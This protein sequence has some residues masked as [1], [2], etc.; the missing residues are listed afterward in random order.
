VFAPDTRTGALQ[1]VTSV[2]LD[3]RGQKY[4][5][6]SCV[7][8]HGGTPASPGQLAQTAP[9]YSSTAPSG[10]YGDVNAGFLPWDLTSF[11]YSDTDPGFSQK[12]EDA[13]LKA[14]YTE[15]N[16]VGQ[17]KLLNVGAYLTTADPNRYALERELLEGWY[18]GPGLP[19]AYVGNFVPA[20]WQ[21]T[22]NGNP[23]T[24]AMLYTDVFAHS[25]RACHIMQA[26]AAGLNLS[27]GGASG[28]GSA[29]CTQATSTTHLGL[30][31]DQFPI[32]C[33]WQFANQ[34]VLAQ[35]VSQARMPFARR[36]ADRLWV[37]PAGDPAGS[38]TSA[39]GQELLTDLTSLYASSSNPPKVVAPGTPDVS[40][41]PFPKSM[42]GGQQADVLSWLTLGVT[43]GY[44]TDGEF[45]TQPT[46]QVCVDTGSGS[47]AGSTQQISVVG[48]GAIPAGFQ[49]PYSGNFLAELDSAGSKL[50]TQSL[51]VPTV[52]PHINAGALPAQ[53]A[54]QGSL[55]LVGDNVV[56]AGNGPLSAHQWWVSALSNLSIASG[57][58]N[59]VAAS[60]C[61]V[62]NSS[63]T[64]AETDPTAS[65]GSYTVNVI[66]AEGT[67]AQPVT[68]AVSISSTLTAA[69]VT[70]YV[71]TN[72][73]NQTVLSAGAALDLSQGNSLQAGQSFQ[74]QLLCNGVAA[75]SCVA[76]VNSHGVSGTAA[77]VSGTHVQYSPPP[78]YA[79][80]PPGGSV[81]PG[82]QLSYQLQKFGAGNV[83]LDQ[84]PPTPF[85]IQVRARVSWD[86]DVV[87]AVFNRTSAYPS[88]QA[89]CNSSGC[90]DGNTTDAINFASS[91]TTDRSTTIYCDLVGC[92]TPLTPVTDTSRPYVD[93]S[94][95]LNSVL[96]RHPAE[97]DT[98]SPYYP[99]TGA[100]RC[101][102]GFNS[103]VNPPTAFLNTDGTNHCDLVNVLEWI[104]DGAN[105]F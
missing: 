35:V 25:C 71:G 101:P 81:A 12:S 58:P 26:P 82:V 65:S 68:Q 51:S 23:S 9:Y 66:D 88:G 3:H 76:G 56:T 63:I 31:A 77:V 19:S 83:L 50:L 93:T 104:E 11:W 15:A 102:D 33:Y 16:Q 53:V 20:G 21:P 10:I 78:A 48:S 22:A 100:N 30:T 86:S 43:D 64:L 4:V 85:Y 74:V 44:F 67:A 34:T 47:C 39:A 32:G 79:T 54:R 42:P 46:W 105:D 52:A 73:A 97:L 95:V 59:C 27:S 29:A 96:L 55:T 40:I 37:D 72:T 14:Q 61:S 6:Q 87:G 92:P 70:G 99:H 90:H 1:R 89:E 75:S 80:N 49:I 94:T 7:V 24:S 36:T 38:T 28:S 60:P 5:P 17:F 41:P 84:S 91:S 98:S 18:G 57:T 62:A 8:C 45:V 103:A 2:D 13:A 69:T